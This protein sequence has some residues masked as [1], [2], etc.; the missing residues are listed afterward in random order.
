M[1]DYIAPAANSSL[2]LSP[3][4]KRTRETRSSN[5]LS[6]CKSA[7]IAGVNSSSIE[8]MEN[9]PIALSTSVTQPRSSIHSIHNGLSSIKPKTDEIPESTVQSNGTANYVVSK[10]LFLFLI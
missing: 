8:V 10:Q 4:R 9:V 3:N 6:S 7:A 2:H 1:A 5:Y